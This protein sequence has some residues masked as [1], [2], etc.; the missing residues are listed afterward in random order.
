MVHSNCSEALTAVCGL[1]VGRGAVLL[2]GDVQGSLSR[3]GIGQAIYS[4]GI[5]P[6]VTGVIVIS[7]V[8]R[9]CIAS[10]CSSVTEEVK[11]QV[12]TLCRS[13]VDTV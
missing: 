10:L 9:I 3:G 11:E 1:D 2:Q 7:A 5:E 4:A 12:P 13:H 8:G 6:P